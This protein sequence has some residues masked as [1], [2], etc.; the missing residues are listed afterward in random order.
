MNQNMQYNSKASMHVQ[1][2]MQSQSTPMTAANSYN[3]TSNH[4]STQMKSTMR[5]QQNHPQQQ[6]QQ[7]PQQ[8]SSSYYANQSHVSSHANPMQ[9]GPVGSQSTVNNSPLQPYDMNYGS[10]QYTHHPNTYSTPQQQQQHRSMNN[11]SGGSSMN[12]YQHSP[13]PGNPT[14]PLTPASNIPPYLSPN[15][16]EIK[17]S[18][19]D[20]KSRASS[21]RKSSDFVK[22]TR[23]EYSV[24]I[25]CLL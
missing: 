16:A 6:Q 2:G 5:N 13:I 4:S 3:Q 12:S 17:T 23:Q 22:A 1:S 24:M 20:I 10:N 8:Y 7:P 14:P 25:N 18:T 15:A 19:T 11:N 9:N 21:Q